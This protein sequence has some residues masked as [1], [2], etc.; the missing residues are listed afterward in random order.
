MSKKT[1]IIFV[2]VVVGLLVALVMFGRSANPSVDVSSIDHTTIQPAAAANGNIADHVFGKADSKVLLIEYG[3][4]QCPGCKTASP[5]IKAIADS[6]K[7]QIGFIFRNFPLTSIHSNAKASAAAVEA[8][9]LQGK[10][11]EMHDVTYATQTTWETLTG[12]ARTDAFVGY[13]KEL[14]LD[15]AKFQADLTEGSVSKKIAFD[16]SIA[17]K[18]GVNSTPTF[19]LNGVKLDQ[20]VW[21]S[22][23]KLKAAIEAELKKTGSTATTTKTVE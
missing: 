3:D 2:V 1:W 21:G 19:Y 10:Y 16:Q 4:F 8:A 13:A 18:I 15:T 20:D 7:D 12:T 14:G 22:D 23:A 9:G 6:Y 5:R 11:W 17:K